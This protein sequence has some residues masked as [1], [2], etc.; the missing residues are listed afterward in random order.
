MA[1]NEHLADRL[2]Q[3]LA[4]L[5]QL[6]EKHMFGGIAFMWKGKML[7]GV[8]KDDLMCRIDPAIENEVLE[9]QGARPMD[10]A[11][12]PMKGYV[13]VDET[14]RR[15]NQDLRYWIDLCLDYN[16]KAKATKKKG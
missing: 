5:E 11:K 16:P 15:T 6:E 7:I 14:G 4:S 3:A 8:I 2:R 13:Y 9:K 12:R 10:F 1:Y